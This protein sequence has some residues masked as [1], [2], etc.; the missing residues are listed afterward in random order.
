MSP[1]TAR[2]GEANE[3]GDAIV[4]AH[5]FEVKVVESGRMA[6]ADVRG[7]LS[8]DHTSEFLARLRPICD[9]TN[10]VVLDLRRAEYVDSDG[11]R[12]LLALQNEMDDRHGEL[13]LVVQPESRVSRTLSLLRLNN[14]F[15]IYDSVS[16]AWITRPVVP[17]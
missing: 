3:H 6:R 10:R 16:D 9:H 15:R 8:M 17:S 14:R 11:V 2:C 1:R 12:A 7:A 13:R 5:P 4:G